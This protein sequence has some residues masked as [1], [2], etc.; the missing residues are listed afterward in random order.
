MGKGIKIV[1]L[2]GSIFFASSFELTQKI[3][4]L[5]KQKAD[6]NDTITNISLIHNLLDLLTG[7]KLFLALQ[8]LLV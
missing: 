5:L 4:T 6:N 3:I 8:E 2:S 1:M 7:F